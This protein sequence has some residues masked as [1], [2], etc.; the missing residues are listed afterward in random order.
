MNSRDTRGTKI[1]WWR[2][3]KSIKSTTKIIDSE[4]LVYTHQFYPPKKI[5]TE[6]RTSARL[7]KKITFYNLNKIPELKENGNEK[8]HP[9]LS[10]VGVINSTFNLEKWTGML[11]LT[12]LRAENEMRG[13]KGWAQLVQFS[14]FFANEPKI[15]LYN[16]S[17][18]IRN[19]L[20]LSKM[21]LRLCR[22]FLNSRK[23][24]SY[25]H[26]LVLFLP[27]WLYK[28]G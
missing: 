25:T 10:W 19:K 17:F 9:G 4:S 16:F 26:P 21:R 5:K 13:K 11:T 2:T 6:V 1:T 3:W 14:D 15:I 22:L 7:N 28:T 23:L 27:N 12:M 8:S 18:F 24:H 20:S